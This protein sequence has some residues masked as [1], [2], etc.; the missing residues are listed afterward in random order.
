MK[1]KITN[2]INSIPIFFNAIWLILLCYIFF[3]QVP[4]YQNYR[5]DGASMLIFGTLMISI[6]VFFISIIYIIIAN[7]YI[8]HKIYSDLGFVFIP[9]IFLI[10]MLFFK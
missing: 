4:E 7:L 10:M 6:I 3:H 1:I 2:K 9:V 5:P 8:R